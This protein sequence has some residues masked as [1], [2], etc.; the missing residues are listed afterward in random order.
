MLL[1]KLILLLLLL[2]LLF[3]CFD[4]LKSV[5]I[6]EN[7]MNLHWLVSNCLL[8]SLVFVLPVNI[9]RK[10][11]YS[12][13]SDTCIFEDEYMF[14]VVKSDTNSSNSPK[15]LAPELAR[16]SPNLSQVQ[17]GRKIGFTS[18]PSLATFNCT[19]SMISWMNWGNVLLQRPTGKYVPSEKFL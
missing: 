5:V 11:W 19:L 15:D 8:V 3:L 18:V 2:I 4:E 9:W 7:G 10:S 1:L 14:I 16:I 6:F 12:L 13:V 17:K